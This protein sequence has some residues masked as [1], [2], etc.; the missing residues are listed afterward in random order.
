LKTQ[1]NNRWNIERQ[2]T[3]QSNS[4]NSYLALSVENILQRPIF[5]IISTNLNI[6]RPKYFASLIPNITISAQQ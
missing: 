5:D 3:E 6:F 2:E 4:K 1:V